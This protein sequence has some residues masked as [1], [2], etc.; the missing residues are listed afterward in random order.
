MRRFLGLYLVTGPTLTLVVVIIL[1]Q[2]ATGILLLAVFQTYLPEELGAGIA[3]PGYAITAFSAVKFFLHTPA[4]VAAD[5]NGRRK[6]LVV[7]VAASVPPLLLMLLVEDA[8]AFIAFAG[9]FGI[10][11]AI[12]WPALYALLA[13]LQDPGRRGHALAMINAGYLVGF[14]LGAVLGAFVTDYGSARL[15]FLLCLAL[16]IGAFLVCLR[17]PEPPP[18]EYERVRVRRSLVS[19]F[20]LFRNLQVFAVTAVIALTG[21]GTGMLAPVLRAYA[22][23]ELGVQFSTFVSFMF[24][25]AAIAALAF[26]PAGLLPDT[27]G[28]VRSL[29]AGLAVCGTA[30][31]AMGFSSSPL[32]AALSSAAALVGFAVI[33]PSWSAALLAHAPAP[34]RGALMGAV[35]GLLGLASVIGP[36]L[37]GSIGQHVGADAA[38]RVAGIIV[39]AGALVTGGLLLVRPQVVR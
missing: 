15:G 25:P 11:T 16:I 17:L 22:L 21:I 37:G 26:V 10:G 31:L 29:T 4:G 35:T 9:L 14:G 3:Y 5:R 28:H 30:I 1:V 27:I 38:F 12:I 39:I 36:A 24:L 33:Q 18:A 7:G 19:V 8:N 20:P 23:E 6:A 2:A 32:P 34:S 13:D